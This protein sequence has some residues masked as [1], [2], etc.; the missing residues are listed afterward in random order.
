MHTIFVIFGATG[1]LAKRKLFPA[2]YNIYKNKHQDIDIIGVGRREFT[3]EEFIGYAKEETGPF[4]EERS[5]FDDFFRTV[6]YSRVELNQKNDYLKLKND[7]ERLK[8]PDSQIIF[9]LSIS[10]EFF[11]SFIDNYK[12][13]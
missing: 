7:I 6:R 9:Y 5:A 3:D 8:R 11:S 13:I 4:I 12:A 1:D 10:P 2:L